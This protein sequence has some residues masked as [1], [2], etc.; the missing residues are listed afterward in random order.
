ML[1]SLLKWGFRAHEHAIEGSKVAKAN[2]AA[3]EEEMWE[4]AASQGSW[5]K[6]KLDKVALSLKKRS[7]ASQ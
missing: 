3:I 1:S 2:F 4:K 7:F 5:I 6:N